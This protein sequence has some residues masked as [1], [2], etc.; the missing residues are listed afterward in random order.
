MKKII[1]PTDFSK[2]SESARKVAIDFSLKNEAELYIVNIY[3]MPYVRS[4][5]FSSSLLDV[6]KKDSHDKM[7]A[8]AAMLKETYSDLKFIDK[9]I[10]GDPIQTICDIADEMSADLIVMGTHGA[11]GIEEIFLGSNTQAVIKNANV[12]VLAIPNGAVFTDKTNLAFAS[13]LNFDKSTKALGTIKELTKQFNTQLNIVHF[14]DIL[15]DSELSEEKVKT[16]FEDTDYKYMEQLAA[17]LERGIADYIKYEEVHLFM[18]IHRKHNFWE[19]LFTSSNSE[20]RAMHTKIPLLV[21]K[22]D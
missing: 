1:F 20:K 3:Q 10:L 17:N 18:M 9:C 7:D 21:L 14:A 16:A 13:D 5:S 19:R 22:E 4:G 12:P 2:A 6:I 15:E 8:L 11:S